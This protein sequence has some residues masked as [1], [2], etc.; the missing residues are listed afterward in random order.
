[1]KTFADFGIEIRHGVTGEIDTTCPQCS[2]QRKKKRARCLSVNI[3]KGVWTCHHCGWA[4]SLGEGERERTPLH[5]RKPKYKKPDP[6]PITDLPR[7]VVD[8]FKTRGITE[9]VLKRNKIQSETV[10]MPQVE[11][12]VNAVVFP[13]YRD[14]EL[15]NRKYR[16]GRKNF[17]MEAGAER[18][19]YGFDDINEVVVVVEGEIDKLSVEEA[20]IISCIS[21][22]DGAPPPDAKDYSTK[23]DYLESA[24]DKLDSVISFVIAVDNDDPGR[25][26]EDE[27]T[28]R[29]GR[30]RCVRVRFPDGCKDANDTLVNHGRDVLR[31]C[32]EDAEPY[33]ISGVFTAMDVSDRIKSLY[34]HGWEK[35]HSTGW[36]SVNKFYTVRPGEFTVVTGIPNSGKSNW[37]DALL[38]NLAKIHGW[39]FAIF[40]PENQPIE[41]HMAR[42]IEKWAGQPFFDGPT[43]RMDETVLEQGQEWLDS[44]F[45]WILPDEIEEWTVETVLE[46][47][48][49]LV[50]RR[51]IRGLVIDPW[52]EL[53]HLRPRDMSETEYVSVVL[54]RVRDFARK[55]GVHVWIIAHPA[56]LYKQKDGNYP[57]PTPYDI[58]GSAHW[59]NKADNCITVWRDF[60]D[61]KSRIVD[62]HVQKIRFRQIGKIG[63]SELAF[64]HVTHTYHELVNANDEIPASYEVPM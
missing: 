16:D 26:L 58:A 51:G 27:L 5:W 30:E 44:H 42:M 49:A 60:T 46:A 39:N 10:Y 61:D 50:F 37:M 28:R 2:N 12:H 32:I 21:V 52:N 24:K 36:P 13:Y 56:K 59:R 54:K 23:F 40:S 9:A 34:Q 64:N 11:D 57:I 38:V 63:L 35:G 8:W 48:K 4:G 7:K 18:I 1:M 53:E 15:I 33:P 62:I 3:D 41:D 55:H 43:R 29:I 22:P 25:R 31:R 14:G 45:A 17:R 6:K 47:A 19:L 20:G